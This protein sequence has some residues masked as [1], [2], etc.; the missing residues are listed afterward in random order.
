MYKFLNLNLKK[1]KV[2]SNFFKEKE[3][4]IKKK[5]R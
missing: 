5:K 2:F 4:N 1:K 3:K